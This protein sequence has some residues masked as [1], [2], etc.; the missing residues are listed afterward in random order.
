[1]KSSGR[2]PRILILSQ[3]FVPDPAS[4]GQ[5]LA[6]V[7]F[8]LAERGY[9]VRVL[10]SDRGYD[11][12]S[13][14]YPAREVIRGV[15]VTRLSGTSFGKE[16]FAKRVLATLA[17]M[18]KALPRTLLA[19]DVRAVIL[20]T[21]PPLIGGVGVA[22]RMLRRLPFCYW[23]MD[24]NPDQLIVGGKLS[25]EG[26][27][28]RLLHAINT[29]ILERAA[30]VVAL[31]RFMAAR[32]G[33]RAELTH[34]LEITPPWPAE[35][36]AEPLAHRDNPFRREHDL[37]GK[38]VVM[39]SGNHSPSNPLETVLHAALV[40][41]EISEI[42]FLFVGGGTG[43]REVEALIAEHGLTN[44][45]SL[46]Y[47]PLE[48]LRYSL[49][50]ADVHVVSMGDD[51]VGIIHPC[52]VYGAMAVA[53]PVLY[54]GPNP[55][56]VSELLDAEAFGLHVSHGDVQG[57]VEAIEAM[58]SL[59]EGERAQMGLRGQ[60]L[61]SGR[62]GRHRLCARFCDAVERTLAPKSGA[63]TSFTSCASSGSK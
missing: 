15:E 20:S 26:L 17:F 48:S 18:A 39:Y 54:V 40:L 35:E 22:L 28:A 21:S 7:A 58:R 51:M 27:P 61:V 24:L 45:R 6:D 36:I 30:L 59:T 55:S 46:P 23:V 33:E 25:S 2:K 42:V 14:R 32:L 38:F 44:V 8:E 11:D 19:N 16:S 1:M 57:C 5:H 62:L 53:R 10:T 9:D 49:S 41:R 60:H 12:P 29:Q 37:E 3:V 50:A 43:K 4:V 31:D 47:Q 63:A 56:H 52:K 13:Q 34:K